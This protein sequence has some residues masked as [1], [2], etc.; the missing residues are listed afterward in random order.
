M[1]CKPVYEFLM[2]DNCNNKCKFCFQRENP[3]ILSNDMKIDSCLKVKQFIE[4]NRFKKGSHILLV[5]GELFD[6]P[7]RLEMFENLFQFIADKMKKDDI[8]FFYLNTNLIFNQS[9][10][11]NMI[12]LM[13]ILEYAGV[14]NKIK[15]TSSFDYDGRFDKKEKIDLWKYNIL[16]LHDKC[17]EIPLAV[18]TILTKTTCNMI[19]SEEL[20][21]KKFSEDFNCYVNL[22][23]YIIYDQKLSATKATI[24]SSLL[25]VNKEFDGGYIKKYIDNFDLPQDKILFYYNKLKK[26]YVYCSSE[27]AD[28]GHSVNFK[29]YSAENTCFVCDLKNVFDNY[30]MV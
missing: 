5:G 28:C 15:F 9:C 11:D 10:L 26:D 2:W 29:R 8:D 16:N 13:K 4:S 20:S 12:N 18:N 3:R 19:N 24:F 22:I 23:P 25:K 7:D 1:I 21:V 27:L 30:M 14:S 6:Q 17:P